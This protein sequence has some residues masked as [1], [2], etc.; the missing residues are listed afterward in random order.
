L[1]SRF[2]IQAT[3]KNSNRKGYIVTPNIHPKHVLIVDD[4]PNVTHILAASLE[5]LG[6]LVI[7]ETADGFATALSKVQEIQYALLIT[8]YKMSGKNGLELAAAVRR[9]SPGTQIVLMTAYGNEALRDRASDMGLA[10]FLDKPF[11]LTQIREIVQHAAHLP[12][13]ARRVLILEDEDDLRR[14]YSRALRHAGYDVHE[15]GTLAEAKDLLMQHRFD[16]F[17]CDIQIGGDRGTILLHEQSAALREIGTQV[18]MVSAEGQYR[19]MC[20]EMGAEFFMQKPV[21][22]GPLITLVDRLTTQR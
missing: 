16:A 14:I 22:V 19:A 13:T 5:K 21:A 1:P 12:A 15:A 9:V 7:V 6:E 8:D 20:E 2:G 11:T 18:I 17:L 10:G 3:A 4:E